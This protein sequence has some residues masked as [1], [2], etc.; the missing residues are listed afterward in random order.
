MPQ[1]KDNSIKEKIKVLITSAGS[2][3]GVNVIKALREQKEIKLSLIAVDMNPLAAG[4][5]MAEKYYVIPKA[6]AA[7]FIPAIVKI[8]RKEKIKII[9]PTFSF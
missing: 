9:I 7:D 6:D 8:C 5:F 1:Q 2:T 4:F 3:N